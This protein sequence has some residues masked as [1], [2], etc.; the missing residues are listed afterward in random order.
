MGQA[1][2][3]VYCP[4]LGHPP[5]LSSGV[6]VQGLR[7]LSWIADPPLPA[8]PDDAS[9]A[10]PGDDGVPSPDHVAAAVPVAG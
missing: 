6:P 1:R 9:G 3:G 7:R 5:D 8:G 4:V 10:V 2:D